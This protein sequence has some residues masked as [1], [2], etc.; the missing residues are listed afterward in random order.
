MMKAMIELFTKNQQSTDTTL[1]WVKRSIA[2][3]IDWVDTLETAVPLMGQDK[4][5]DKTHED[6]YDKEE[7][8]VEDEE[9]FNPPCPPPPRRQHHRDD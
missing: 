1:E 6:A 2:R 9:P 3:I 4:P 7:E 5:A 8:E